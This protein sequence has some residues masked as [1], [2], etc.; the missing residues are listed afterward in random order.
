MKSLIIGGTSSLG[1]CISEELISNRSKIITLSR[2]A[3]GLQ[4]FTHFQCD[5]L[6]QDKLKSILSKIGDA[7]K[8][9]DNIL[10]VAGYA[11]PKKPEEQTQDVLKR[12]LDRNFTYVKTT[13]ETLK[14]SLSRSKSPF[15]VTFGSQWSYR[16]ITDCPE[17]AAYATAKQALRKYT[18]DFAS[19]NPMIKV[20]HYCIPTTDTFSYRRIEETFR[21]LDREI[22][23]SQNSLADPNLIAKSLV[24]HALS[25]NDS[26]RTLIVNPSGLV[27]IFTP[28]Y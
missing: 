19:A 12:H 16:P 21:N 25:F 1:K 7:N 28:F 5:V 26:G 18:Q 24:E 20:N 11:Y 15:V 4:E 3:T 17:L 27:S 8:V 9:I 23:K 6:E 10:C 14:D 22:P 2:S 13:L